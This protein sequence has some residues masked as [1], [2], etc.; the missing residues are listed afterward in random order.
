MNLVVRKLA[1]RS[2]PTS[3]SE[4]NGRLGSTHD[5]GVVPI[6]LVAVIAAI[7]LVPMLLSRGTVQHGDLSLTLDLRHYIMR[8]TPMWNPY[9]Q[10]NNIQ[11]VDRLW[12]NII[13][14]WLVNLV[15]MSMLTSF[16]LF[17]LAGI[18]IAAI[19]E[20]LLINTVLREIGIRNNRFT[21]SIAVGTAVFFAYSPWADAWFQGFDFYYA[22]A[23]L[24]ICLLLYRSYLLRGQV[25]YLVLG[26]LALS[27]SFST[28]H[29]LVVD[30]A[31][32]VFFT[33]LL[34]RRE[35]NRGV[36][37]IMQRTFRRRVGT[38]VTLVGLMNLY[39]LIP[40]FVFAL[41]GT[42]SPGV[43]VDVETVKSL[44]IN[45]SWVNIIVGHD[46]WTNWYTPLLIHGNIYLGMLALTPAC[47]LVFAIVDS[48]SSMK[49][50]LFRVIWISAI[51]G[52]VIA[53]SSTIPLVSRVYDWVA[54][55][56]PLGWLLRTPIAFT[57]FWWLAVP[58]LLTIGL[59][60]LFGEVSGRSSGETSA[61]T[62][63]WRRPM[64]ASLAI[65][66]AI[67]SVGT[68]GVEGWRL[69]SFYYRG[70]PVPVQYLKA[71]NYLRGVPKPDE[72]LLLDMAP[73]SQGSGLNALHYGDS[74]TWNPQRLIGFG[75]PAS[76]PIPTIAYY[77]Q[78]TPMQQY[79]AVANTLALS[80]STGLKHWLEDGGVTYVLFHNDIV[81]A[82]AAGR[83]QLTVLKQV[84]RIVGH[85]GFVYLF[86][87]PN[88]RP[89]IAL[90]PGRPAL[91]SSNLVPLIDS[92]LGRLDVIFTDE[93][94]L[95]G[96]ALKVLGVRRCSSDLG[97]T[98]LLTTPACGAVPVF[99]AQGD[100][101]A[102]SFHH[103]NAL[104]SMSF[105]NGTY[106]WSTVLSGLGYA[107]E[108]YFDL[109]KGAILASYPA[110]S[111]HVSIS[112]VGSSRAK[113]AYR[114]FVRALIGPSAGR[115]GFSAD[116]TTW[117]ANLKSDASAVCWIEGPIVHAAHG[118]IHVKTTLVSGSD[119]VTTVSFE[120]LSSRVNGGIQSL[121]L[122]GRCE[123]NRLSG[124]S[125]KSLKQLNAA[126][127]KPRSLVN[128]AVN[129]STLASGEPSIDLPPTV[130]SMTLVTS[131]PC[132]VGWIFKVNGHELPLLCVDGYW[133]STVIAAH[134]G[135]SRLQIEYQPNRV[136]QM[137]IWITLSV[138][139]LF[140]IV[141]GGIIVYRRR[142]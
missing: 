135:T 128:S 107:D 23:L 90:E 140:G 76:V 96:P 106:P 24:P 7:P 22:Y 49:S 93:F 34:W 137:W 87:I 63:S 30:S 80:S 94:P 123:G 1:R 136:W 43:A 95:N 54:V 134:S 105:V 20:L 101:H 66:L 2:T 53:A 109:G 39:W 58:V 130:K 68:V 91:I 120:S 86:K 42:L 31:W 44:T 3:R 71:Y 112:N 48:K 8:F 126:V 56:L 104:E 119:V 77:A 9:S 111:G 103:W 89:T 37:L 73:Y 124:A 78:T 72:Q 97:L 32:L 141:G 65:L 121:Y 27:S 45:D 6:V 47:A 61:R 33:L 74:Y 59:S 69:W 13:P 55:A 16:K 60:T 115:V 92:E 4:P 118:G 133:A 25:R 67:S 132:G 11:G 117:S 131:E 12:M 35:V 28:P 84:G 82:T 50:S 26:A 51:A 108:G 129:L 83:Q 138:T 125:V 38:F 127:L 75:L 17:F 62:L 15:G 18:E 46:Q 21:K 122:S 85:W 116:G 79:A 110:G 41:Q 102:F 29:F 64:V 10:A 40:S 57:A 81:G 142:K 19:G 98:A 139:T 70:I 52:V 114:S 113:G 36:L 14:L 99:L 100:P 5:I 88:S